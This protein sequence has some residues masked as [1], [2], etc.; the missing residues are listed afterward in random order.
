MVDPG[1]TTRPSFVSLPAEIRLRIYD[2]ALPQEVFIASCGAYVIIHKRQIRGPGHQYFF[3]ADQGHP[4]SLLSTTKLI[5]G[6]AMPLLQARIVLYLSHGL[7]PRHGG[8]SHKHHEL[9]KLPDVT[10]LRH[11]EMHWSLTAPGDLDLRQFQQLK[12]LKIWAVQHGLG[13]PPY[14]ERV[15]GTWLTRRAK[16]LSLDLDGVL[17]HLGRRYFESFWDGELQSPGYAA[18]VK[19]CRVLIQL[20]D[21]RIRIHLGTY[22]IKADLVSSSYPTCRYGT[23]VSTSGPQIRLQT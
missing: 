7:M 9:L 11:V 12:T 16:G 14:W 2:F 23:N 19:R 21:E 5:R 4:V 15:A 17:R 22:T 6:E 20:P 1:S 18:F 10:G 3:S 13:G 8:L